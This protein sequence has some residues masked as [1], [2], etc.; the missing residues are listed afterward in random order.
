MSF[1]LSRSPVTAGLLAIITLIFIFEWISGA[2]WDLDKLKAM[3]AIV[4][5]MLVRGEYWRIFA[6]MFLHADVLHWAA[7]S[8]AL[9]QLGALYEAMFG[10][11]RFLFVYFVTGACASIASSLRVAEASVGA[12]GAILGILGAFIFSIRRSP[13]WRHEPWTKGLVSQLVFWAAVN[14][15]IGFYASEYIDNVAHVTGLVT[16]LLLGLIPHRVPP[17][18][19]TARVIDVSA[20]EN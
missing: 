17:P 16:G 12:S 2:L 1:R 5:G 18:P 3:G 11:R 9:Y 20:Y 6:A 15:A 19:P 14:L 10:T 8:W 13:Q 4:P 7:N